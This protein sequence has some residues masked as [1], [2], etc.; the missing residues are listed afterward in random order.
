MLAIVIGTVTSERARKYLQIDRTRQG[1]KGEF[2]SHEPHR[3]I[4]YSFVVNGK[5]HIG[6]GR[7]LGTDSE[8][9]RFR[10]GDPIE[11]Y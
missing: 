3:V 8:W 2:I 4:K 1:T 9:A 6:A 5:A 11:V 7:F 10:S